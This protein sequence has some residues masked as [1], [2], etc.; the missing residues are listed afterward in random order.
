MKNFRKQLPVSPH[1]ASHS[2][3][4]KLLMN[5]TRVIQ[6]IEQM[7]ILLLVLGGISSSRLA[8]QTSPLKTAENFGL[9][10]SELQSIVQKCLDIPE[11][12]KYY[13]TDGQKNL[14][15][16]NIVQQPLQLPTG[17]KLAKGGKP[18]NLIAISR[19]QFSHLSANAYSMFRSIEVSGSTASVRFNYFYRDTNQARRTV[20]VTLNLHNS[21]KGWDVVNST[22]KEGAL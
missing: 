8:A 22:V 7:L 11:L 20:F 5:F 14:K 13:P 18:V 10:P 17:M 1:Q 4:H 2:K 12:Q 16:V 21:T 9:T 3:K 15:S 19:S 6:R